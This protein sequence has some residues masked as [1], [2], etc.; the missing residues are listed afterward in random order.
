[1]ELKNIHDR[2]NFIKIN[3]VFG[4]THGGV[5]AEDGFANNAKLK[6]TVLGKV[7]NGLFKGISWLWRKS[8]ENFIIN[9][10]IAQLVNELMR[11]IILFCFDNNISLTEGTKSESENNEIK[12][13]DVDI[14]SDTEEVGVSP[15]TKT[16]G[17]PMTK[18]E[19][20]AKIND[21][22]QEVNVAYTTL[23]N[24]KN[25]T[26][27]INT[28]LKSNPTKEE[29]VKL[30]NQLNTLNHR[31][32]DATGSYNS[33][34]EELERL[35]EQ[36]K[37]MTNGTTPPPAKPAGKSSVKISFDEIDRIC[38]EKY[39]FSAESEFPGGTAN[40]DEIGFM[41]LDKYKNN[42]KRVKSG[43]IQIDDE[44]RI[45]NDDGKLEN[46]KVHNVDNSTGQVWYYNSEKKLKEVTN[47]KLLPKDFPGFKK[48]KNTCM[49]FLEKYIPE[50]NRMR[51]EDKK[52]I[53]TIY[54][55]YKLIE[56]LSKV[57][58]AALTNESLQTLEKYKALFEENLVRTAGSN[59]AHSSGTVKIKPD[60]PRAGKVGLGK[61]VAM[62]AVGASANVGN[63]L[64]K[65][66]RDKY[67]EKEDQFD[68]DIHDINLA[69]IEKT[70]QVLEKSNSEVKVKV[71]TYVNPYN[72]KTIQIS[73]EQLLAPRKTEQG[74]ETD[75]G[76]RLRWNKELSK[77]YAAFTNIMDIE[78]VNIMKEDYGSGL[79]NSKTQ[80]SA[81][82]MTSNI[83]NQSDDAK[84]SS[85]LPLQE[86]YVN[87][88]K[89]SNGGW[90][91]YS[92]Y[93]K[94]R[95]FKTSISPVQS[96]FNNFGLINITSCF[97][98]VNEQDNSVTEDKNF[99]KIFKSLTS[100]SPK[101][102]NIQKVKIYF[103]F[104]YRQIFPDSN[105]PLSAKVFV[106]NEYIYDN[107]ESYIFLKKNGISQNVRVTQNVID[108]FNK[109]D[110]IF[111]TKTV[112]CRKFSD[113]IDKWESGLKLITS[114]DANNTD[115][116]TP[117]KPKFLTD[118]MIKFL[119]SLSDKI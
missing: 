38:R 98:T 26:N 50:Y 59:L 54:M 31:R 113:D 100:D 52:R 101:S 75:T 96:T 117:K 9:R 116:R 41:S 2:K 42:Y 83:R 108:K 23:E 28:K 40:F 71:S 73:A 77:T 97:E 95:L 44:Y 13:N 43:S 58:K 46:I 35:K 11:G 1:M 10:L 55:Q 118:E 86:G 56:E 114:N 85:K 76:L 21:Q 70:I 80:N 12:G 94:G 87:Y 69:E 88:P 66:D 91:Y 109:N 67:K 4:G 25:Q 34:V 90:F 64:T 106:L 74:T 115:F 33:A 92:F 53:E 78:K 18:K 119:T 103:L 104:K 14:D 47:I 62:K 3:E 19:L 5:G 107:G 48:I 39:D 89:M 105:Q 102:G 37:N 49:T 111:E 63:I 84:S 22:S 112:N 45:V 7:I 17:K 93:F 27:Q 32:K 15:E 65:R 110:Y 16:P 30:E 8:K 36:L 20:V 60:E 6:D 61:S 72:L 29:K 24:I 81:N 51:D 82:N 57:Q 68:I 99:M 79:N